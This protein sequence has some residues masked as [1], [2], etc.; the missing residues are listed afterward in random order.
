M[1]FTVAELSITIG[2]LYVIPETLGSLPSMVYRISE[3]LL[4]AF[5]VIESG[6]TEYAPGVVTNTGSAAFRVKIAHAVTDDVHP[7]LYALALSVMGPLT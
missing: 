5:M 7:S 4:G 6:F 2:P 1:A 3:P